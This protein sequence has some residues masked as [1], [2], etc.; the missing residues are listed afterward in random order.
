MKSGSDLLEQDTALTDFQQNVAGIVAEL[1]RA[2]LVD[3]ERYRAL[4]N[5]SVIHKEDVAMGLMVNVVEGSPF[6]TDE[7]MPT[8]CQQAKDTLFADDSSDDDEDE[9][10]HVEE[11]GLEEWSAI[12]PLQVSADES[13]FVR[14]MNNANMAFA[15][16]RPSVPMLVAL[17][18]ATENLCA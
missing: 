4:A 12:D 14:L 17:R 1:L 8:R 10:L 9:F 3:A 2:A 6:W 5:R 18:D 11:D 13:T 15:A 7:R 16:W